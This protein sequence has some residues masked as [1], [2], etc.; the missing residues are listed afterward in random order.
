MKRYLIIILLSLSSAA[1]ASGG[2][3]CFPG[4]EHVLSSPSH[5]RELVWNERKSQDESHQL[6][7]RAGGGRRPRELLKFDREICIHWSPGEKYFSISDYIGSNVAEVYIYKSDDVSHRVNVIDLLPEETANYF[8]KG[9]LHGY[10]ETLSWNS[11]GLIVRAFGDRENKPRKFDFTLKC[12]VD[13]DKWTCR[14]TAANKSLQRTG[15]K[16]AFR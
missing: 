15:Q 7:Y 4:K 3:N 12:T 8:R 16:A 13:K 2:D 11:D 14:K 5:K 1:P 9:V 10:I 6:L